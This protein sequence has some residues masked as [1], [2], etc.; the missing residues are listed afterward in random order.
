MYLCEIRSCIIASAAKKNSSMFAHFPVLLA[1]TNLRDQLHIFVSRSAIS[2]LNYLRILRGMPTASS[3][4]LVF[5][6]SISPR[7][8]AV[9]TICLS[10][11]YCIPFLGKTQIIYS[12]HRS[13]WSPAANV[14]KFLLLLDFMFST[15]CLSNTL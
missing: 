2:H 7:T 1:E 10:S 15:T 11:L 9:T 6:L 14:F 3:D 4:L 5:I 8:L 12:N 13:S